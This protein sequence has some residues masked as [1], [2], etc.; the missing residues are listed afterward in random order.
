MKNEMRAD[1]L[2]LI[3]K[4]IDTYM[5]V[6][7][8]ATGGTAHIYKARWH[9][10]FVV[11][12]L[13]REDML[14]EP[15]IRQRLYKEAYALSQVE[16]PHIIKLLGDGRYQ[17]HPYLVFEYVEIG[18]LKDYLERENNNLTLGDVAIIIGQ[19]ANALNIL[20]ENNFIHRDVKPGNI[21]MRNKR[22]VALS[23]FGIVRSEDSH[24][25]YGVQPGTLDFMAPEQLE[26]VNA[27]FTTD[28]FALAVVAFQALTGK[29]PFIARNR[30]EASR[31]RQRGAPSAHSI[32]PDLPL[33]LDTI[34]QRA[35]CFEMTE[36][37][38][39]I[40]KFARDI[41]RIIAKY[42]L[43]DYPVPGTSI[44]AVIN[45]RDTDTFQ[46]MTLP[47]PEST[48]LVSI[49]RPYTW[50]SVG[51]LCAML[52]VILIYISVPSSQAYLPATPGPDSIVSDLIKVTNTR[53]NF[54]CLDFMYLYN[55][56]YTQVSDANSEFSH[57]LELT[58]EESATKSVY[59]E[60]CAKSI[61][62]TRDSI[63][64]ETWNTM[65]EELHA[66]QNN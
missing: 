50:I 53:D 45:T 9:N 62:D 22:N 65:R 26:G 54:N 4:T 35:M 39:L 25:R 44:P 28:Q 61:N 60:H 38:T 21:M 49:M 52:A 48:K 7:Y 57:F 12:K 10:Q 24:S 58:Y 42:K 14:D 32:N 33:E 56:L 8:L 19:I 37:Y 18:S 11:M 66:I 46:K 20:H 31:Q 47:E 6:D 17:H 16:H 36:R 30:Q 23:D 63:S 27:D 5:I 3:G 41:A 13:L 29:R 51:I 34:L 15:D 43:E 2:N 59:I 55:E 64:N 1:P 40:E